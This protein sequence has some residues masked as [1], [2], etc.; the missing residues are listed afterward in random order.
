MCYSPE[1]DLIAGFVVGAIAIDA[2]RHVDDRDDLAIA[3][4]PLLLA[5]HQLTEAVAWWGLQGQV[6]AAAGDLAITAYLFIALGMVPIAIPYAV[7]RSEPV[8]ARQSAMLPFALLGVCVSI[9]LI[10]GLVTNPYGA[11]IGGHYLAYE[12][13]TP[14]GGLTAGLY[15]IAVCAPL[16][17]SSRRSFVVFGLIN[18]PVLILLSIL[19]STGLI[20]L[21]CFWAAGSSV[22]IARHLRESSRSETFNR[23]DTVVTR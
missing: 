7:M 10:A 4:V 22:L 14:G 19:L 23:A 8:G 6:P 1:A 18:I 3:A 16:L 9:V 11:T 5:T 20:S 17:M 21:W 15:G 13:T 2:I 12:A